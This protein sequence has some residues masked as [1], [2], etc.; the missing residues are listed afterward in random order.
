MRRSRALGVSAILVM[1]GLL[2]AALPVFATSTQVV[3]GKVIGSHGTLLV[4][5]SNSMTLYTFSKD[6]A[7]SGTSACTGGCLTT[8]PALT[9]TA[10][11]TPTGDATVTGQ[12]GTIVRAD[13]GQSQVTYNGLPLYFFSKDTAPGDTN[14]IYPNWQAVVLAAARNVYTQT[15][16]VSDIAGVA[17]STDPNLVNPWGIS[18]T[19]QSPIWV[20]D[21]HS[22][23][24]TLYKGAVSGGPLPPVGLVVKIPNGSPTGQVYNPT[25]S[26]VV[27][28][29]R[30]SAPALFIFASEAG[31]IT[32]WNAAVPL[33][34]PSTSAQVGIT[35]K[36]AVY[37]GLALSSGPAG[38]W[39]YAA[40]FHA[41]TI[42]VFDSKFHQVHWAGAFHDSKIPKG[43]A[44]FNIQNLGDQLFV[45]YAVQKPDKMDDAR[46][47]GRGFVDIY[48]LR[49]KLL[50]RLVAHGPLNSPWGL[51]MAPA[52][53]GRFAGDLLVGNFGNGRISAFDP[54]TGAF[55]GQLRNADGLPITIDGLW[56][57]MFGNGVAGTPST[58]FFTAG[59]ADETHG[60][61]G[62]IAA[63]P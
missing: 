26:W 60:L 18:A 4:A 45:T 56:G 13:N 41:A 7:G 55:K 25:K 17:R 30:A 31:S 14:G 62:T 22:N 63:A 8:W 39:L 24:T 43:Y 6:V 52:D 38:D 58:L 10:G 50:K 57:L 19:P 3:M 32:G 15:N 2:A 28:S 61:L 29:G 20:S 12:L 33:P 5:A 51:A 35:V 46:G 9:V 53:F 34:S 48:D 11:D 54:A 16:L 47:S 44:P 42:D 59:L 36:N 49:G 27:R 23:A 37:K 1:S 21:N 40:N